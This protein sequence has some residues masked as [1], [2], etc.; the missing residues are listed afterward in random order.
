MG[1]LTVDGVATVLNNYILVKNEA[2]PA[3]NGVY[4]VTTEGTAGVAF[5]LTRAVEQDESVEFVGAYIFVTAGS[6]AYT[7]WNC[8]ST[9][10]TVGTTAV[11]FTQTSFINTYLAGTGLQ[12]VGN[13]FSITSVVATL[14][15]TQTLTNKS[16]TSPIMTGEVDQGGALVK[17]GS[18]SSPLRTGSWHLTSG[19]IYNLI[20]PQFT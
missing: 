7:G 12:L 1:I 9:V 6:L 5:I 13:T 19:D 11:V 2:T 17:V 16:L 18:G 10:T 20:Q 4:K 15:G 8:T 3:Y 14:T